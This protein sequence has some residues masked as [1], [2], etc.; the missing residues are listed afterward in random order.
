MRHSLIYM[1]GVMGRKAVNTMALIEDVLSA[2]ISADSEDL[3]QLWT[4]YRNSAGYGQI[5][6]DG[7]VWLAHRL[8]WT[9]RRGRIPA[10]LLVLHRCDT[11]LCVNPDHLFLGT[12]R[13][14]ARDSIEKGRSLGRIPD[15]GVRKR[16]IRKLTDDQVRAIR[17]ADGKQREIAERFGVSRSHVAMIRSGRAKGLITDATMLDEIRMPRDA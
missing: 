6:I 17:A 10:G 2:R 1:E 5:E 15:W 14:N 7:R 4:G 11:P 9:V 12:P 16:R 8:V 3:C 13:D